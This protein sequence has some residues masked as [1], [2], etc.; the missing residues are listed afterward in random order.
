ME[1]SFWPMNQMHALRGEVDR[2]LMTWSNQ[3]GQILEAHRIRGHLRADCSWPFDVL[4]PIDLWRALKLII[5]CYFFSSSTPVEQT[6]TF[7][8]IKLGRLGV[9]T[10][11]RQRKSLV[12]IWIARAAD[13]NDNHTTH[14]L[15]ARRP[16]FQTFFFRDRIH[17]CHSSRQDLDCESPPASFQANKTLK[18][19]HLLNSTYQQVIF[20]TV[21]QVYY[22]W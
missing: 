14:C 10:M 21:T 2:G 1:W 15:D 16:F 7:P 6:Y 8:S 20:S 12:E 9:K 18:P 5:G 17:T 4:K 13:L 11:R 22:F 3:S 19:K